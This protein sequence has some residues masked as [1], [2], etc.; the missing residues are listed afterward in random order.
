M[1]SRSVRESD[2][3][4]ERHGHDR[5][6]DRASNVA[7]HG[8]AR[9]EDSCDD[10]RWAGRFDRTPPPT[11]AGQKRPP[12][13]PEDL[14]NALRCITY[15]TPRVGLQNINAA[16]PMG[17]YQ[18]LQTPNS[19]AALEAIHETRIIPLDGRPHL[20]QSVRLWSGDSRGRWEGNTLIVDTTNFSPKS[21]FMGA[22]K[23][24]TSSSGSRAWPTTRSS[25]K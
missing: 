9:R 21:N 6:R 8:S 4:R 3:D 7:H 1:Q 23:T 10:A 12:A 13:G 18:I 20:P 2:R 5:T 24:F 22:P 16:G 15:G 11:A 17:Y 19:C 14:S 25:T